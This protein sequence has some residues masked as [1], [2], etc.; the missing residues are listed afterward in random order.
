MTGKCMAQAKL[1]VEAKL[2]DPR[3]SRN[4]A[5]PRSTQEDGI[6]KQ[7]EAYVDSNSTRVSGWGGA[8][9]YGTMSSKRRKSRN[10]TIWREIDETL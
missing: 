1:I 3:V 5:L 9:E 10:S 7:W 8:D 6:G 2:V 4:L